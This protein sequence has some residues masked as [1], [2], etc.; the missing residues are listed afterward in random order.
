MDFDDY[1]EFVNLKINDPTAMERLR[2]CIPPRYYKLFVTELI[3]NV[4]PIKMMIRIMKKGGLRIS[5]P[6]VNPD[7]VNALMRRKKRMLLEFWDDN[8]IDYRRHLKSR[9]NN[10]K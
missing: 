7:N 4:D 9:R 2:R 1:P 5:E 10:N 6:N 3:N 8:G